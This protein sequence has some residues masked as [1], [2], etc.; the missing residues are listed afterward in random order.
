MLKIANVLKNRLTLVFGV[1]QDATKDDVCD[2]IR[3]QWIRYQNEE[4]PEDFY[5]VSRTDESSSSRTQD[6]Y[7]AYA[8]EVCDM[9]L[10]DKSP[11]KFVRIDKYW[12]KLMDTQLK[13]ILSLLFAL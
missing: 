5:I 12:S 10:V 6:S 1:K 9:P 11:N 3:N 4:N 13:M 7:W 2:T 8:H